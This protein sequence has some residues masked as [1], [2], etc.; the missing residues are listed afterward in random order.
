MPYMSNHDWPAVKVNLAKLLPQTSTTH[1]SST[2]RT[3]ASSKPQGRYD[4][5]G[6]EKVKRKRQEEVHEQ[7]STN[8]KRRPGEVPRKYAQET[9]SQFTEIKVPTYEGDN[10]EFMGKSKR[11]V[12]PPGFQPRNDLRTERYA[13]TSN[14][15]GTPRPNKGNTNIQNFPQAVDKREVGTNVATGAGIRD[16]SYRGSK[17]LHN[18]T[19][20]GNNERHDPPI[21]KRR[22]IE[23][24]ER[25]VGLKNDPIQDDDA[26]DLALLQA[27]IKPQ[28]THSGQASRDAD[29]VLAKASAPSMNTLFSKRRAELE[30]TTAQPNSD[31][32]D[33][34][35]DPEEVSSPSRNVVSNERPLPPPA[36]PNTLPRSTL[37]A[38]P[39]LR[40]VPEDH[41]VLDSPFQRANS[42]SKSTKGRKSRTARKANQ[43]SQG[44]SRAPS[45]ISSASGDAV[46]SQAAGSKAQP[47][48][49][50]DG[51]QASV[52][53]VTSAKQRRNIS[54]RQGE[55]DARPPIDLLK[56]ED[57]YVAEKMKRRRMKQGSKEDHKGVN[58]ILG[59]TV[60]SQLPQTTQARKSAQPIQASQAAA[61]QRAEEHDGSFGNYLPVQQT[62][63]R[64]ERLNQKFTRDTA[65]DEEKIRKPK[66]TERMQ[67]TSKPIKPR[68][69]SIDESDSEED[70]LHRDNNTI[71]RTSRSL[72]PGKKQAGVTSGVP[73]SDLPPTRFTE[74][75]KEKKSRKGD[76]AQNEG[77]N[78]WPILAFY[79]AMC[80]E[81]AGNGSISLKYNPHTR[82]LEL[83]RDTLPVPLL[84]TKRLAS[85]RQA[86]AQKMF[87]NLESGRVY[88][89]GSKT[90][91]SSGN[92]CI[93]F[94]DHSGVEW[95]M[96]R[97]VLV[98][99]DTVS[100]KD[101]DVDNLD[102]IFA[103]QSAQAS[104][105]F[106]IMSL[107]TPTI[108]TSAQVPRKS[109]PRDTED[110]E[111]HIQ[112]D[113]P[114]VHSGT[115]RRDAMFAASIGKSS[116]VQHTAVLET[117]SRYFDQPEIATA[118]RRST[119]DR[120]PVEERPRTPS[121]E[122]W[123]RLNN[124]KSWSR[125]VEYPA[126]AARRVTVDFGDIDRL[127]EGQFLNDN[128][129]TFGL[130]K[131][132]E[133]MAPEYR[134]RTHFFNTFFYTSLSNKNGRKAFNYDS[135][136]KWTKTV[137]IFQLP[138]VVVPINIDLH[139]FVAIIC[140]LDALERKIKNEEFAYLDDNDDQEVQQ[141][142]GDSFQITGSRSASEQ[143]RDNAKGMHKLSLVS[144]VGAS[145]DASVDNPAPNSDVF[146]FGQDGKVVPS[147]TNGDSR[148]VSE[149]PEETPSKLK[150]TKRKITPTGRKYPSD[151]PAII[152]LDSF[153]I[154][155]TLETKFLKQYIM[156]EADEKRSMT[157]EY[158]TL[159]GVNAKGIPKQANFCDCGV[160]LLGYVEAFSRD[161]RGFVE[162]VL[163][164]EMEEE[165]DFASFNPSAKRA[166][167][168]ND[169]FKLYEEQEAQRREQKR[170]KA[171][172][173]KA[174]KPTSIT[175]E[176]GPVK[177]PAAP[178]VSWKP[179]ENRT[180]KTPTRQD[181][182]PSHSAPVASTRDS[183]T[184]SK[185][186]PA[187][188]SPDAEDDLVYEPPRAL[189]QAHEPRMSTAQAVGGREHAA[190]DDGAFSDSDSNDDEMLD[191]GNGEHDAPQS[192]SL[193]DNIE[194]HA[195]S[196]LAKTRTQVR[197]AT[198][199]PSS[200]D[201]SSSGPP[202]PEQEAEE[203]LARQRNQQPL[204]EDHRPA[205]IA[206]SQEARLG[207]QKGHSRHTK[208]DD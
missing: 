129:V 191:N 167:I 102:K 53:V 104:E 177:E 67:K 181:A 25:P 155:H 63:E 132:Q 51:S 128:L 117:Q 33:L 95:L 114:E 66:A 160:Y 178:A 127:D 203:D 14:G 91:I 35:S 103:N 26:D 23:Q 20:G 150:T 170:A 94:E 8:K 107:R 197:E 6:V 46:V 206:D 92:I 24:T 22:K 38:P 81:D 112:Y 154:A 105:A 202:S 12:G 15:T 76:K 74:S 136:K 80:C 190:A 89:T 69:N 18:S 164:R 39:R 11:K 29:I 163:S 34:T 201:D 166:N 96:R 134:D 19:T 159:Q 48:T 138:F 13:P 87:H 16:E 99:N 50:D 83:L 27:N 125:A 4:E 169:L 43:S 30:G 72:S 161:P 113:Q 182:A 77:C 188:A 200:S 79:S 97:L 40:T 47:L 9:V 75:K 119:R 73:P 41:G 148:P 185:R 110:D 90:D 88:I 168:R 28:P 101:K 36:R 42:Y 173:Q 60:A 204:V 118:P 5:D 186:T 152:T 151:T 179:V 21:S 183:T 156:A 93:A 61:P 54:M 174:E 57:A 175:E 176:P 172:G 86:D 145:R 133:E 85:I 199:P 137:D 193:L 157:V 17:V 70:E 7:T 44:S 140:N 196:E 158:D 122:R 120:K 147:S 139:W 106:R 37:L 153:G 131:I 144:N 45:A 2:G 135:V 115:R 56:D 31:P 123:T 84:G 52:Q 82:E 146:E 198:S 100:I 65:S 194:D 1:P 32:V 165:S 126:N 180:A 111:E 192:R 116:S 62:S 171:K 141:A 143:P 64:S 59:G 71:S 108:K 189:Q 10:K 68:V 207:S 195:E 78:S 3:Q 162:K 142:L 149:Q 208:F 184:T 55:N 124:P 130:R 205:E 49:V 58:N 121:P 109:L 187:R 98:T